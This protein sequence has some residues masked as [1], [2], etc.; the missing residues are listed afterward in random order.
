[1]SE[2]FDKLDFVDGRFGALLF[3]CD[4]TL[5]DTAELHYYSLAAALKNLGHDLPKQWYLERVGLSLDKL[6]DEFKQVC[7]VRLI[8]TD[9]SSFEER[10][11][12]LNASVIQ[13]I[14]TVASI[15]RNC[16]GKLPMGVVSSSSRSMVMATLDALRLTKFFAT[17]ITVE[18]VESP[19]PSP[20]GFLMAAKRLDVEPFRCLVF[21]D[22]EQGLEAASKADMT[23]KDVRSIVIKG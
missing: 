11:F 21:E 3:D 17:V 22:S 19:K 6:L 13:E 15:V 18:D 2:V 4:G 1:M 12:C 9:V 5:A 7:G 8:N 20:D 14:A 10:I 23:V 16:A